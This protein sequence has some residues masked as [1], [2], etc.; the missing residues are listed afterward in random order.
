M[1]RVGGGCQW[2]REEE[3]EGAAA[4]GVERVGVAATIGE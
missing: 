3:R 4:K 1:E 2:G